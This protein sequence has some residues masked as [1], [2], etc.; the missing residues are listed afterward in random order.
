MIRTTDGGNNWFRVSSPDSS[1]ASV[2]FTDSLN[3]FLG[4]W[5]GKIF[6]TTD[7]GSTWSQAYI[8]PSQFNFA[9]HLS[10]RF[11][12]TQYGLLSG[13]F[14]EFSGL[15]YRTTTN[16]SSWIICDS[17]LSE[18]I[19]DLSY[20]D[21]NYVVGCG[22]DFE[23]GVTFMSSTDR[24]V[25]WKNIYLPFLGFGKAI[26]PRTNK[27]IWMATGVAQKWAASFDSTKTWRTFQ[28]PDSVA[29]NYC[30]F[31]DNKHGWTN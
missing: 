17:A 3:G 31:I 18:P 25:N 16:G 8:Y 4:E 10:F 20:I 2:F 11:Y 22:G 1:L 9:S 14:H 30:K 19:N 23:F 12:N 27:E 5:Y 24:G 7:G 29:I 28:C 15:I 6:R 21:S 26:A 13:G